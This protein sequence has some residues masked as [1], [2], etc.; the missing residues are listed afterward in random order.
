MTHST[1]EGAANQASAGTDEIIG[2]WALQVSSPFGIQPIT[3]TVERAGGALT[4]VMR[5]ERGAADVSN[6]HM[7]GHEFDAIA[8]ITLKGTRITADIE[9]RIA[10]A[11]IDGTVKVHLPLAPVVKFTGIKQ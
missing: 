10:G 6:I 9:G 1:G 7:R 4:G 3:F 8:A 11:Q 2:T 5:H